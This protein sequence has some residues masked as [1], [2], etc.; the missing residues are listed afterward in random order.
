MLACGQ[1]FK[2]VVVAANPDDLLDAVVVGCDLL[3]GYGPVFLD[4]L[5]RPLFEISGGVAEGDG[6]PMHGS[7]AEDAH[8]IDGD[9]IAIGVGNGS[10]Y[11]ALV[12]GDLLLT[13]EP[14]KGQFVRPLV[15]EQF[16]RLDLFSCFQHDD[17]SA[18]FAELL[19]HDAPGGAG[20]EDADVESFFFAQ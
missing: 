20:A 7:A 1:Y 9:G 13:P 3:V 11:V 8:S 17:F 15:G 14:A 16:P 6:V 19:S 12:E 18:A 2:M 10:C 5:Q 4:A